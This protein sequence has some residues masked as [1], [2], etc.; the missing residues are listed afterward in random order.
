MLPDRGS[1]MWPRQA[2]DGAAMPKF[3]TPCAQDSMPRGKLERSTPTGAQRDQVKEKER[4]DARSMQLATITT[5]GNTALMIWPVRMPRDGSPG[6]GS[7]TQM[8]PWHEKT[9]HAELRRHPV[10]FRASCP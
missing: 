6:G 3:G 1:S 5:L 10:S 8:K 2:I 9:K 4:T 7:A